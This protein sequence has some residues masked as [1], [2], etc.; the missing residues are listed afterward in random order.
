MDWLRWYHGTVTDPKWRVVATESEQPLAAVLAVWAAM[1]ERASSNEARGTLEGW[2]DRVVAA[3]LDLTPEAV[4]AIREAMDGLTVD[5][6]DLPGWKRRQP[7][8]EDETAT[9]RKR[10]QRE[11][12][13][14]SRTVTQSHDRVDKKR[15]E[16]SRGEETEKESI[17]QTARAIDSIRAEMQADAN[18]AYESIPTEKRAAFRAEVR[19]VVSGDNAASWRDGRTGLSIPWPDRPPRLRL[20]MAAFAEG[21]ADSLHWALV[22]IHKQQDDPLEL[23][24]AEEIQRER[25][26]K[27][28]TEAAAVRSEQP[29][30]HGKRTTH[31]LELI[32]GAPAP[33]PPVVDL[34]AERVKRWEADNPE[35]A[36][37]VRAVIAA[38]IASGEDRAP[39]G[40][41]SRAAFAEAE[42]RK[43]VLEILSREA[44]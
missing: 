23:R 1:L 43:R 13:R 36:K 35:E 24:S 29:V 40:D 34:E 9:D 17:K 28:G 37:R 33:P 18:A 19:G 31:G 11:R 3:A 6:D 4:R 12:E 14:V 8:R 27:P 32:A 10:A 25:K 42:Y 26:P 44:A 7:K 21:K 20:A 39:R 30:Q 2:N 22:F 15:V 5:G 41:R 38:R 16:E